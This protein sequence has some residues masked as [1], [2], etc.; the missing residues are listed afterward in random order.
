M[1]TCS[2]GGRFLFRSTQMPVV[3]CHHQHATHR[4]RV[5]YDASRCRDE[6][7][8]LQARMISPGPALR[9]S[10]PES[11]SMPCTVRT[12]P[13]P[14]ARAVAPWAPWLA[15][16]RDGSCPAGAARPRGM[17]WP[18]GPGRSTSLSACSPAISQKKKTAAPWLAVARHCVA[19]RPTP[20]TWIAT[21]RAPVCAQAA[22]GQEQEALRRRVQPEQ[23]GVRESARA[24]GVAD[25]APDPRDLS[26]GA[27]PRPLVA[28]APAMS[29]RHRARSRFSMWI[30][31][32]SS[33]AV[34]WSPG[35]IGW[36][37]SSA[38]THVG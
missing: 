3:N 1:R 29:M 21:V 9:S 28:C 20:V 14:A 36:V 23:Q 8:R 10:P 30:E 18:A 38:R 17:D 34:A 37:T 13:V 2:L 25:A 4:V 33:R 32:R 26:R 12:T 19:S 7:R 24:G 16:H 5:E 15:T 31:R 35:F 22:P 6:D 11:R 27:C